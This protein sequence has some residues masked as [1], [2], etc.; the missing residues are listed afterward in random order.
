MVAS[1]SQAMALANMVLPV[2]GGA[3]EEDRRRRRRCRIFG[4]SSGCWNGMNHLQPNL[5]LN[6]VQPGDVVE[7]DV[8]LVLDDPVVGVRPSVLIVPC[9]ITATGG[10]SV[11][12]LALAVAIPGEV[13]QVRLAY[14]SCSAR[15]CLGVLGLLRQLDHA[16]GGLDEVGLGGDVI[17][18]FQ[19]GDALVLESFEGCE[20]CHIAMESDHILRSGFRN[21]PSHASSLQQSR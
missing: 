3:V 21:S 9:A 17:A 6:L 16:L 4:R 13:D 20:G 11:P 7:T 15:A 12:C 1:S 8:W 18:L 5:L 10:G 19:S 2:P 14:P